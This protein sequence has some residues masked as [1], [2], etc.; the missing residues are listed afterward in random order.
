MTY[1]STA[2]RTSQ[3][4]RK[5]LDQS[6][7]IAIKEKQARILKLLVKEGANL[8]QRKDGIPLLLEAFRSADPDI[9]DTFLQ[10]YKGDI[11][12]QVQCA[13]EADDHEPFLKVV[14][15]AQ[16][17]DFV[18]RAFTLLHAN[19][20][21]LDKSVG[22]YSLHYAAR[23]APHNR[24]SANA[25][26]HDQDT[27]MTSNVCAILEYLIVEQGFNVNCINTFSMTPLYYAACVGNIKTVQCLIKHGA[28]VMPRNLLHLA[29]KQGNKEVV[30]CLI[31]HGADVMARDW[32]GIYPWT[33]ACKCEKKH[34]EI[35][36]ELLNG[37][38][39]KQK[40]HNGMSFLHLSCLSGS[41]C[42]AR[43]LLQK[44]IDVNC[45]D[46]NNLT[47][48]FALCMK[49]HLFSSVEFGL[50]QD[51]CED[52]HYFCVKQKVAVVSMNRQFMNLLVDSGC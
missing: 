38:D 31:K 36:A 6:V 5:T 22:A 40:P 42:S 11:R 13:S 39:L 45:T 16:R 20:I 47:P 34:C 4:W 30:Q 2:D 46:E 17:L 21:T 15:E 18:K 32:T 29:V 1:L 9:L 27:D 41:M 10:N 19:N 51:E 48:L 7:V 23:L 35:M 37:V 43:Y 28:D 50:A 3:D 12:C 26:D 33:I 14:I 52:Y 44:G 25:D 8:D 24:Q 49:H